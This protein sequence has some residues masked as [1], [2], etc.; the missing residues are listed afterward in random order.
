[1]AVTAT[2]TIL[3]LRALGLGDLLTAVPALRGLR[4]AHPS[5]RI[6]LATPAALGPLAL[7][8]AAVDEVAPTT[9]LGALH[10]TGPPPALAVNLHGSG[11]GSIADL[12]STA[13]GQL[14]THR[15]RCYPHIDG[16]LWQAGQHEV[17][18]WCALL[19]Q[20]GIACDTADLLLTPPEVGHS[21]SSAVVIH[22]G[23]ASGARRW[24][25]ERFAS[26]AAS[27]RGD[28]YD[29]VVTGSSSEVA[30]ARSVAEMAALPQTAVLAG[31]LDVCE[32]AAL[33]HDSRL[34]VCGDTGVAHIAT[35][36]STPSVVIFGPTPPARWGPRGG[37]PHV[38]LWAGGIGDPHADV[39]HP[40]LLSITVPAVLSAIGGL[41]AVPA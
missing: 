3:V 34:V 15:H 17:D 16:P 39:P 32:L 2:D 14:I 7:L 23:A 38:S 27:L 13:P 8:S 26:V 37:G 21:F 6:V 19:A 31:Q 18:R 40:G 28:G 20:A 11:P 24:P 33:V 5:A 4:R 30:L 9:G 22:P 12:L 1:M 36:M 41:L 29:V 10:Y 35:A 25:A